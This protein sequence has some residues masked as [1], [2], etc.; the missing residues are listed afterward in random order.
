MQITN[1]HLKTIIGQASNFLLNGTALPEDLAFNFVEELK[2]SNLIIPAN[3]HDEGINFPQVVG[4][5]DLILLPLFTDNEEFSKKYT[6]EFEPLSN[7]LAYYVNIIN[8]L[9]FD[10]IIINSES[11]EFFIDKYL[12]N[13]ITP[14]SRNNTG[15]YDALKLK[16]IAENVSNDLLKDIIHKGEYEGDVLGMLGDCILLN[17]VSSNDVCEDGILYRHTARDF[18]FTTV[19]KGINE[20]GV[21]FTGIDEIK[22]SSYNQDNYYFQITN[23]FE[24]FKY[25]LMNDLDGVIVNPGLEEF[26]IERHVLIRIYEDER[27]ENPD[28]A[29]SIDYA[30]RIE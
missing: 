8:D 5:N 29:N 13:Q 26:Y 30:F 20:Y 7:E 18:K 9:D 28:L 15:K 24:V 2:V 27:L 21:L 22:K 19:K 14:F 17:V 12:L 10:G 23:Y 11:D 25:I 3:V 4:N 16:E 6:D 1:S